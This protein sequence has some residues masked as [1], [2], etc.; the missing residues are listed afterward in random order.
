MIMMFFYFLNLLISFIYC[1]LIINNSEIDL[2]RF[3][4]EIDMLSLKAA[5]L[6]PIL[7]YYCIIFQIA[8]YI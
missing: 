3:L 8:S 1:L 6:G 5:M 4:S 7:K 2:N